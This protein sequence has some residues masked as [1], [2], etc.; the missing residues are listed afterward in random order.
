MIKKLLSCGNVLV[1]VI[2]LTV[3]FGSVKQ[4]LAAFYT[5]STIPANY[6]DIGNPEDLISLP[7]GNLWYVDSTNSRLVKVDPAGNTLRT[8]GRAGAGEGEFASTVTS[9]ARDALGNI[10]VLDFYRIYKL[11][12][13]G[14]FQKA[15]G[16]LGNG[17]GA[18]FSNAAAIHYSAF[19]NTLLVSDTQNNRIAKFDTD[20]NFI[21]DFGTAGSGDGQFNQPQGLT[22]DAA[23]NIYVVDVQNHRVQVFQEDGTFIMTFG[24]NAPLVSGDPYYFEFPKDVEILS[25]GDILVS[26]QNDHRV[27]I[28]DSNGVYLSEWAVDYPQYLTKNSDD[29]IWV[30]GWARKKLQHFTSSGVLI[31]EIKNSGLTDGLFSNPFSQDFDTDGNIYVLDGTGRVQKFDNEGVFMSTP[32]PVGQVGSGAYH[33]A[34]S[35]AIVIGANPSQQYIAVSSET[36]VSVFDLTGTFINTIGQRGLWA[37]DGTG[38]GEFNNARGMDFDSTGKL[39]VVDY[40]NSRVQVFDLTQIED[41]VG[42]FL[43]Q[44]P[45]MSIPEN[46]FIDSTDNVYVSPTDAGVETVVR[47]YSTVGV[48][49]GL[50]LDQFGDTSDKYWM[51]GGIYVA[52]DGTTYISDRWLNRVQVYDSAGVYVE[53]IGA[54]GS[55]QDQ[56]FE[57]NNGRFNPVTG[58]FITADSGN[59]RVQIFRTGVK[60]QNLISSADVIDTTSSLS[61]VK[62]SVTPDGNLTAEMYFGDYIVSDFTVD[63]TSDRNWASVNAILLPT[64]S[65]SLIVNLNPTDAPGVSAT[66]SLYVAKK[67]GQTGVIVCPDAILIADVNAACANGYVLN[68]GDPTL[69]TVTINTVEY[70]KITGLTGTGAM[71]EDPPA[72]TPTPT[73]TAAP[74]ATPTSGPTPTPTTTSG[75]NQSTST[76]SV[77]SSS[78]TAA[79]CHLAPVASVPDLFQINVNNNYAKLFFTPISNTDTFQISYSTQP[80]AEEHGAVVTLAREGVQNF[81]VDLLQPNTTY[82]FKVRGHNGCAVGNWSN[83]FKIKTLVKANNNEVL[84]YK[85]NLINRAISKVA[86]FVESVKLPN[87]NEIIPAEQT[88]VSP[89]QSPELTVPQP[90]ITQPP[91]PKTC[92]LWN[93]W[94]F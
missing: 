83:I 10:Y 56:F 3:F 76:S 57:V 47:K 91:K 30:A 1:F 16:T 38:S 11:D 89:S 94:C 20:G 21:S 84:L 63:L 55:G 54:P 39:Y 79:D 12:S 27:K 92:I 42:G 52:D 70:W 69:T 59:H 80:Q 15:W 81:R 75:S 35:P 23:G 36:A 93:L 51:I 67:V 40:S 49:Q 68:E 85:F 33:M 13:N 72:P 43:A 87:L 66:H 19:N 88:V 17:G 61:L 82:Y 9:V 29:S 64:E 31:E 46:I 6:L 60:I 90:E 50:F 32:I 28:F 74:T 65:K 34:I 48:D 18:E 41:G 71:S 62:K 8:V 73:P 5:S 26:S 14:G 78:I 58:D 2:L 44:W 53:S 24:G 77:S 25:N 45:V 37:I 22:T 4:G 7:D 86:K